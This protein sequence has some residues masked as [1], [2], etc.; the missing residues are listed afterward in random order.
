M[1]YTCTQHIITKNAE[2]NFPSELISDGT[3][4]AQAMSTPHDHDI[5]VC[6]SFCNYS[7]IINSGFMSTLFS[8][9]YMNILWPMYLHLPLR[10]AFRRRTSSCVSSSPRGRFLLIE[11]LFPP[12]SIL[13][14]SSEE[15][16][17]AAYLFLQTENSQ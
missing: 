16:K 10:L 6:A 5:G 11:I 13:V 7:C 12:S 17:L 9:D 2:E 15:F 4:A 1:H 14:S 8:R 3:V